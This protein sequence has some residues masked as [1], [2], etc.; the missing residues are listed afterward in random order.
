M[1]FFTYFLFS[2]ECPYLCFIS[3]YSLQDFRCLVLL[4]SSN[5][6]L[7]SYF[8]FTLNIYSFDFLSILD[9]FTFFH[10]YI[11]YTKYFIYKLCNFGNDPKYASKFTRIDFNNKKFFFWIGS[12][13]III[14]PS[15]LYIT[16]LWNILCS[17][18]R[19]KL[20]LRESE[21]RKSC[22]LSKLFILYLLLEKHSILLSESIVSS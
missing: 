6:A 1:F 8:C 4:Y 15:I 21:N 18:R 17:L 22:N 11:L 3:V 16:F 19:S 9:T 14:F 20:Q 10:F 7:H 2:L 5:F 12:Y 13:P